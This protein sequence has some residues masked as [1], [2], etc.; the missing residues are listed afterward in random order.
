MAQKNF[1]IL[2]MVEA[3]RDLMNLFWGRLLSRLGWL[4]FAGFSRNDL[5]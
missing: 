3:I 1:D 5:K 2:A 4:I